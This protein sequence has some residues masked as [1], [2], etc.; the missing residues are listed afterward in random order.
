MKFLMLMIPRICQPSTPVEERPGEGF[1]PQPEDLA[2]MGKFNDELAKVGTILDVDGLAPLSKG[3]RVSF[4][5]GKA[6]IV[7]DGPF[8]ETNEVIGG[9]WILEMNSKEELVE[10][11]KRC[12]AGDGDVIEIRPMF[13]LDWKKDS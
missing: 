13:E 2:D 5:K 10:W 3:A 1:M 11:M 8:I 9:Y 12:P 4:S 7:T 6:P